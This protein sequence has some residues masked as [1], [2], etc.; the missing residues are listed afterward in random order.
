LKG[1]GIMAWGEQN[2]SVPEFMMQMSLVDETETACMRR[3][4]R[5]GTNI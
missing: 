4:N 2:Q 5:I 3:V 1:A